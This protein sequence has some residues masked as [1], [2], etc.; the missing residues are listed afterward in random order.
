ML[1]ENILDGYELYEL[2]DG[3]EKVLNWGK[4][5]MDWANNLI[6]RFFEWW[7]MTMPE[8]VGGYDYDTKEAKRKELREKDRLAEQQRAKAVAAAELEK[9][10]QADRQ[11]K[12]LEAQRVA[13]QKI[14]D[15][16]AIIDKRHGIIVG[17][18][19]LSNLSFLPCLFFLKLRLIHYIL[20]TT[21]P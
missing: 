20:T 11:A 18:S 17:P 21:P 5:L 7:K 16:K 9:K 3:I 19:A 12:E 8:M 2:N 10:T 13:N 14:I 4:E 1:L 6:P 15:K